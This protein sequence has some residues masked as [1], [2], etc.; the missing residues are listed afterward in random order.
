MSFDALQK[1]WNTLGEVDPFWAILTDPNKKNN[2]WDVNLFFEFGR[3][4]INGIFQEMDCLGLPVLHG[5]ALDFGCGVGRL[6]QALSTHFEEAHGVD[7]A[8]SM[9][10]LANELKPP[11]QNCHY[12][13]NEEQDLGLFAD[14][15]F[16]FI[17]SRLVLQH[18]HPMFSKKYMGEFI[19]VLRP[20]GLIAFQ[21]PSGIRRAAEQEEDLI[22]ILRPSA[23]FA[24]H[25][26]ADN[27][28]TQLAANET[29]TITVTLQNKSQFPWLA[30][31]NGRY[32][33]QLG[34]H[35]RQQN[36]RLRQRDDGR[37]PLLHTVAPGESVTLPLIVTAPATPGNYVLEI[38]ALQ[39]SITWFGDK[40]SPT[41]LAAVTVTGDEVIAERPSLP[42]PLWRRV[43]NRLNPPPPPDRPSFEMHGLPVAEVQAV[44][45][46]NGGKLV[47]IQYDDAGAEWTSYFYFVTKAT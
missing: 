32:Q 37:T 30:D 16:D 10:K 9:I 18:M 15:F 12:H 28:P 29:K 17:Y 2:Q 13:L 36:G 47:A 44:I 3:L 35:W 11:E 7:V 34:N 20:G 46:Q 4:E 8:A 33:I 21:L 41:L 22:G 27:L 25:I 23:R 31:A 19:R 24:A 14:D 40:G 26:T 43:L 38:D 45:E 6:T 42:P 1:T 39:E 5:R